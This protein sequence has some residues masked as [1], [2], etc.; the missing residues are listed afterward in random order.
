[1]KL[2]KKQVFLTVMVVLLAAIMISCMPIT[3]ETDFMVI[4]DVDSPCTVIVTGGKTYKVS[5]VEAFMMMNAWP[6]MTEG[7]VFEVH[8]F[9]VEGRQCLS[10]QKVT[11]DGRD[12][13]ELH[14]E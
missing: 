9:A 13:W 10:L 3:S 6:Y 1:M 12:V 5:A 2:S 8:A 11:M 4:F 14:R 7:R